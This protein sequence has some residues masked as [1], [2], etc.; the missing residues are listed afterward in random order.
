MKNDAVSFMVRIPKDMLGELDAEAKARLY[1]RSGFV[2]EAVDVLL[3]VPRER[4]FAL[5]RKAY[6]DGVRLSRLIGE[7]VGSN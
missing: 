5:K 3:R 4:H 7:A 6:Q 2:R 1:S